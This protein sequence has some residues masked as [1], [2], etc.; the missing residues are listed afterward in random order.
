VNRIAALRG[1]VL[2]SAD[3]A[4]GFEFEGNRIRLIN[5]QRGIFKPRQMVHL[6]SSR[7]FPE[8]GRSGLV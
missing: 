6:L 2:D 7:P 3:L 5:S 4:R 1:G 8:K